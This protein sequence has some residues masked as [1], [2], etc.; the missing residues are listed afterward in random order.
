[1]T[2]EARQ[3]TIRPQR[4]VVKSR[5]GVFR[6]E[7]VME[8]GALGEVV[9]LR[10]LH[11]KDR[12]LVRIGRC[13]AGCGRAWAWWRSAAR[14]DEMDCPGCG[15]ALYRTSWNVQRTIWLLPEAV[16][17]TIRVR[18]A[19][20]R[21][22]V[23]AQRWLHEAVLERLLGLDRDLDERETDVIFRALFELDRLVQEKR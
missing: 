5:H 4:F 14:I 1:M 11:P 9:P 2:G 16:V 17:E 12:A 19:A 7:Q 18:G 23:E 8:G 20:A 3:A 10:P 6:A 22:V 13:R 21:S 15:G